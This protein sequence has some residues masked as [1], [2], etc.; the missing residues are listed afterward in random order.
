MITRSIF[1]KPSVNTEIKFKKDI[2]KKWKKLRISLS[3]KIIK[4][5]F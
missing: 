3:R 1:K 2:I 4:F 5:P